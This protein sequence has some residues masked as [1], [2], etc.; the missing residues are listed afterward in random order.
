MYREDVEAC[1]T[2]AILLHMRLNLNRH[3]K[4]IGNIFDN[5]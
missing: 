1:N 4:V 3:V 2:N 5:L